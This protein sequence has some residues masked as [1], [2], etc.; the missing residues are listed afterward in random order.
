MPRTSNKRPPKRQKSF[1]L[2]WFG[3]E[4]LKKLSDRTGMSEGQVVE[5]ALGEYYHNHPEY[6][7]ADSKDPAQ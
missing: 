4:I 7:P 3:F 2:T 1:R 5:A 6:W